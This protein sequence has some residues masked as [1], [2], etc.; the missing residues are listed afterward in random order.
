MSPD[1]YTHEHGYKFCIEVDTNGCGTF[2]YGNI[3]LIFELMQIIIEKTRSLGSYFKLR[4]E[5]NLK[6][7]VD[8]NNF[9]EVNAYINRSP[10]VFVIHYYYIGIEKSCKLTLW[11]LNCNGAGNDK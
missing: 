9:I 10:T 1:M 4:L 7:K 5:K 2:Q 3:R 11:F 8:A 6:T